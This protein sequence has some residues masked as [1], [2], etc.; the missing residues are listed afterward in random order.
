MGVRSRG[1]GRNGSAVCLLRRADLNTVPNP[2][3]TQSQV[4]TQPFVSYDDWPA[5][6]PLFVSHEA[7]TSERAKGNLAAMSEADA[8]PANVVDESDVVSRTAHFVT[9]VG[10]KDFSSALEM[11]VSQLHQNEKRMK[12]MEK[13]AQ[14]AD[15][16][17]VERLRESEI[18]ILE[19]KRQLGAMQELACDKKAG[20]F[21][22]LFSKS[23]AS[24]VPKFAAGEKVFVISAT[25]QDAVRLRPKAS[26]AETDGLAIANDTQVLVRVG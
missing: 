8:A 21:S 24:K 25:G 15:G 20:F 19:L 10:V 13:E 1:Q 12:L 26:A 9:D 6:A 14:K 7:S 17:M 5:G 18:E 16:E 11:A 4:P 2:T 23:T 22:S 3:L